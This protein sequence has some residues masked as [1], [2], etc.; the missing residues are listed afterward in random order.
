MTGY[1]TVAEVRAQLGDAVRL[2]ADATEVQAKIDAASRQID[3]FCE[4]RFDLDASASARV[5][6]GGCAELLV[7]DIGSASGLVVESSADGVNWSTVTAAAYELRPLNAAG[8][9]PTAYAWWWLAESASS[10]TAWAWARRV[11]VTARWGWSAVPAPVHEACVLRAVG[12]FKRKDA[13]HAVAGFDGFG[14]V[15]IRPDGDIGALLAPYVR[16]GGIA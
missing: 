15:R 14:A 13:P 3:D 11:R 8:R 4:R 1:A 7:D 10:V 12:L 2:T 5:Y 9:S 16:P 6:D